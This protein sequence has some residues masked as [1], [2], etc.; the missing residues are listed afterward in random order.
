MKADQ[1]TVGRHPQIGFKKIYA[2]SRR[3]LESKGGVL[4]PEQTRTAM[5]DDSGAAVENGLE[6]YSTIRSLRPLAGA[7]WTYLRAGIEIS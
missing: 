5:G 7:K 2:E 3:L 6:G 4:R 1:S